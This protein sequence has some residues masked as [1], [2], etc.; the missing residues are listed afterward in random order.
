MQIHTSEHYEMMKE[1]EKLYYNLR[2]DKEP[3]I[4]WKRGR[5]YQNGET[6]DK[7]LAFRAGY[8]LARCVYL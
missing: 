3:K 1:F 6:N 8:S 4:L 7:F 2:L 5:I